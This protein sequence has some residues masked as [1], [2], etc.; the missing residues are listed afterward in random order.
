M[1]EAG[2]CVPCPAGSDFGS[3][4]NICVCTGER[5]TSTGANSTSSV[6]TECDSEY[7]VLCIIILYT[8]SIQIVCIYSMVHIILGECITF[9]ASGS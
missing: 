3:S 1:V 5:V 7:I 9:L 6:G 4:D 2:E 8:D